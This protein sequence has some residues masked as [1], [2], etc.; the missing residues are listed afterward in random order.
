MC[1]CFELYLIAQ[2]VFEKNYYLYLCNIQHVMLVHV[3]SD[4]IV[5][6]SY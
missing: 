1:A 2:N 6:L 4:Y 5:Y 3:W